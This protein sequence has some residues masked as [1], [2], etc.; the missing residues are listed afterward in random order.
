MIER[1]F[2]IK[3]CVL[4][5]NRSRA[6][7]SRLLPVDCKAWLRIVVRY[8]YIGKTWLKVTCTSVWWRFLWTRGPG[9]HRRE[10][11]QEGYHREDRRRREEQPRR[12]G[13]ELKSKQT[14]K[15]I[16]KQTNKQINWA[17]ISQRKPY[18]KDRFYFYIY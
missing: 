17:G 3:S 10:R 18:G 2:L 4:P 6:I 16:N 8:L 7:E 11:P 14:N 12:D 1:Y 9:R 15:L 13:P 5:V